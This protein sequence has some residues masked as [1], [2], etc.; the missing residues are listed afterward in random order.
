MRALS[1]GMH[2]ASLAHAAEKGP[3]AYLVHAPSAQQAHAMRA[4]ERRARALRFGSL[5]AARRTRSTK[6]VQRMHMRF[7]RSGGAY[8]M[9][10][11]S[12][13]RRPKRPLPAPALAPVM[14]TALL[15]PSGCRPALQMRGISMQSHHNCK[16]TQGA[17]CTLSAAC[18]WLAWR[19]H[20]WLGRLY[21]AV[22]GGWVAAGKADRLPP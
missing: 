2:H 22:G 1:D 17:Q 8:V 21:R 15:R 4:G 9:R 5:G 16:R 18:I 13:V 10:P 7:C 20:G 19:A 12:D 3:C 6:A 14:T 11:F